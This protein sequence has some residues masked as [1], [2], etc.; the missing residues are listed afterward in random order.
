MGSIQSYLTSPTAILLVAAIG[1][2]SYVTSQRGQ[3]QLLQQPQSD[4]SSSR[5][6]DSASKQS[7]NISASTITPTASSGSKKNKK[8][9]AGATSDAPSASGVQPNVVSLPPAIPG[10]FEPTTPTPETPTESA[11]KSKKKKKAKKAGTPTVSAAGSRIISSEPQSDSSA[12]APESHVKPPKKKSPTPK[13]PTPSSSSLL[14]NDGPWTRV[15]ARKRTNVQHAPDGSVSSS[16]LARTESDA[17]ITSL[18]GT[19]SSV[20]DEAE[21]ET[22]HPEENRRTLAEKLLPKPRKTGVEEYVSYS[23]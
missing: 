11:T 19:S 18:T 10:G 5:T 21:A 13:P 17:G 23:W 14:D 16:A 4:P 20:A 8:K 3:P 15:E 1:A 7:N 9:K 22:S 6:I 12:T 2:A